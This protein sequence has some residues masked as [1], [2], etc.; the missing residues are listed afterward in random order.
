MVIYA[1]RYSYIYQLEV[2]LMNMYD[3]TTHGIRISI[4]ELLLVGYNGIGGIGVWLDK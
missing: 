4:M 3:Q 1:N 2:L